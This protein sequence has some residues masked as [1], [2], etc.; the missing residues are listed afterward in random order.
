MVLRDEKPEEPAE[1]I[2][3]SKELWPG[4]LPANPE[5]AAAILAQATAEGSGGA[6]G[7]GVTGQ[8]QQQQQEPEE[9]AEAPP[10]FEYPFEDE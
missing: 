10:A 2:E 8:A 7:S 1:Y 6:P 9:E 3:L 5:A 4:W